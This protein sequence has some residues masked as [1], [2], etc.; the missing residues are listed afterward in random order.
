MR[1]TTFLLNIF[2]KNFAYTLF[3]INCV[4]LTVSFGIG[5]RKCVP[6]HNYG[7][8]FWGLIVLMFL[9]YFVFK[10]YFLTAG[11]CTRKDE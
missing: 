2:D 1:I 3:V 6:S 11:L 10:R 9:L 7:K 4:V 5:R 8:Q